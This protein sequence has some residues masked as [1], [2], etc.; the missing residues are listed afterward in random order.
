MWTDPV[1]AFDSNVEGHTDHTSGE[2]ALS[3]VSLAAKRN[4]AMNRI[5]GFYTINTHD[6]LVRVSVFTL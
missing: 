2:S 4:D 6:T 5:F 3:K 1:T